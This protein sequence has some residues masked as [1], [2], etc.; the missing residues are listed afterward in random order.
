ML[1]VL[2]LKLVMSVALLFIIF[3]NYLVVNSLL[4]IIFSFA[5]ELIIKHFY[6]IK[7]W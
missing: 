1:I 4:L 7:Y 2:D 5:L 3:F 6:F